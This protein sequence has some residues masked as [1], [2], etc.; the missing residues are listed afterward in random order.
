[1]SVCVPGDGV[2][3]SVDCGFSG[4]QCV[5]V[6]GRPVCRCPVCG[7]EIDVVCGSNGFSYDNPCKLRKYACEHN[8]TILIKYK[9]VCGRSYQ[10]ISFLD[11]ATCVLSLQK[12]VVTS[13]VIT[14]AS[15]S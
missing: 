8:E 15:V 6:D 10:L 11:D 13:P 2:C 9:G 1:M 5:Q 7:H 4:A 14:T 3:K 12:D